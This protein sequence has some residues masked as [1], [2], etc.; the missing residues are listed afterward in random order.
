MCTFFCFVIRMHEMCVCELHFICA[1][2]G[3]CVR[4]SACVC[5][6]VCVR[7]CSATD[8]LCCIAAR[9]AHPEVAVVLRQGALPRSQQVSPPHLHT[10]PLR[11]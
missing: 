11:G 4:V 6:C 1:C 2:G 3:V 8:L 9:P 7:A 10:Q 5:L